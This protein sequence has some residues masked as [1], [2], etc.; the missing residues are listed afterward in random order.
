MTALTDKKLPVPGTALDLIASMGLELDYEGLNMISNLW[1]W[2]PYTQKVEN[3]H[4][5]PHL[6]PNSGKL[7]RQTTLVHLHHQSHLGQHHI[8]NIVKVR[9]SVRHV[10]HLLHMNIHALKCSRANQSFSVPFTVGL[11]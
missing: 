6:H 11:W 9:L 1:T 2:S 10:F 3:S 4:L 7:K 8:G 5:T